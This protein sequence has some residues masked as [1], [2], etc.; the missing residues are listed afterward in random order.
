MELF[1]WIDG[2]ESNSVVKKESFAVESEIIKKYP[3]KKAKVDMKNIQ[4]YRLH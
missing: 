1:L 2:K 3:I 4:N